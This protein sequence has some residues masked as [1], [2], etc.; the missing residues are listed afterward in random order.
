MAELNQKEM[1]SVFDQMNSSVP[2]QS[3]TAKQFILDNYEF[4][5]NSLR[6][7]S[8]PTLVNALNE[9]KLLNVN[10]ASFR[11]A[12]K[13]ARQLKGEEGMYVKRRK[14]E[15]VEKDTPTAE[16]GTVFA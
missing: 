9:K 11:A 6:D 5:N 14:T 12:L 3:R 8:V 7:Y 15:E 10:L 13:K 16:A 4:I 1:E 2:S